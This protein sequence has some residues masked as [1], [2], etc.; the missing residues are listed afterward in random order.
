[1]GLGRFVSI[2]AGVAMLVLAA[3]RAGLAIG[4]TVGPGAGRGFATLMMSVRRR[5][6][7]RPLVAVI[8][9]GAANALLPCGL[10]YA[11]VAAAAA[12]GSIASAAGFMVSF[13]LGTM[14]ML[15][16]ISLLA[17]SVPPGVRRRLRFAAPLALAAVG[18]L[19]I[20]RGSI[21]PHAM[22]MHTGL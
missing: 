14:P 1:M 21:V 12:L 11:A 9:A 22:H 2:A 10:V 15:A 20:V 17:R 3:R 5:L 16:M 13:G 8:A 19:L 4:P 18:V 6:G 7:D